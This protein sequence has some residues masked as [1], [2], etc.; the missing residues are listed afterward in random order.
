ELPMIVRNLKLLLILDAGDNQLSGRIPSWTE[1]MFPSLH[2]LRLRKNMLSGR[3]PSQLC[4][5]SSLRILDL[6]LN[7]LYGSIPWCIG[8]LRGMT[9]NKST[10]IPF[11]V[12][13][14]RPQPPS[15]PFSK[16]E[17][18]KEDVREVMKGRELEYIKILEL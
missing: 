14:P 10:T 16:P 9:L 13:P 1:Q 6:S 11:A 12:A 8:N 7:N 5:L 15:P 2:V 18:S 3:I 17:W 4:N